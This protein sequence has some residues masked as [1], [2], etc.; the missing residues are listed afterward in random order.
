[1]ADAGAEKPRV[2]ISYSRKD[3]GFAQELVAGMELTGFRPHMDQHDIAAGEDWEARLGRLIEAADTVAFVIS[4]DAV[5]SERC[6]WEVK[7]TAELKKRLLPFVWHAV[8]ESEVP[9]RL[10]QLNDIFFHKPHS[11][12][13]S[14]V[15]LTTALR[16]QASKRTGQGATEM[17]HLA[18]VGETLAMH[19]R[20][21][22]DKVGAS[23][24]DR[25]M[26][27][28]LWHSR[29]CQLANAFVGM[30]LGKGDRV[31]VLAYN[32]LEWLE[33]YAAAALAGVVIVP[34]NFRLTGSE[35]HY[36]VENCEARALVVE[37]YRG[38]GRERFLSTEEL[39]RLGDAIREAET[40]GL[41]YAVDETKPN[42]K[43]APKQ[44]N[45]L[46]V[47][48][49]HAAAAM[50]LLLF[51]GARLRE[52]LHLKWSDIDWQFGM[53]NLGDSK[54]GKKA[55]V[56][57]APAMEVL[58]NLPRLGSY[59]IA[60]NSAGAEDEKPRADLKRPWRAVAK[61]AGLEGV[62]IHD[63]RHSYA[64]VGAGAGLGLPIIGK[65]LGHTQAATTQRYAHL[66]DDPVRRASN[67][68]GNAI[69]AAMGDLRTDGENVVQFTG[70]AG[71]K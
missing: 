48:G 37:K 60:G 10:K 56:V 15:E 11:F 54:T 9:P 53:L 66:A 50:R 67:Q 68:I 7:R 24:L 1:M 42:T 55:I 64:S 45:R 12:V 29:A 44:E 36:I 20:L 33:L 17:T 4:P 3:E 69:A 18:H 57:N 47:I 30:G 19:A 5:A 31:C 13:S 51:T 62:R 41:P 38:R 6:A 59:V 39:S 16:K 58:S 35:V 32:C 22:S 46:T 27:F 40:S 25:K 26:T 65:L 71:S 2:F 8:A 52:I 34:I 61:R 43:H 49:P 21:F 70:K 28:R 14:L 63:L 23:D